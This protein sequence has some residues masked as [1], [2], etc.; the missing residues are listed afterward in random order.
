MK[1]ASSLFKIH[2]VNTG[3][4]APKG[5]AQLVEGLGSGAWLY[6]GL[7]SDPSGE[8]KLPPFVVSWVMGLGRD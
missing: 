4:L 7:K 6:R 3:D 1:K 5:A 8:L 2:P